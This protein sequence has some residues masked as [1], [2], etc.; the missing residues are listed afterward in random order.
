MIIGTRL[1]N[2]R[3]QSESESV[4][5]G[6]ARGAGPAEPQQLLNNAMR[7]ASHVYF[8]AIE[9]QVTHFLP[10]VN[11]PSLSARCSTAISY[12]TEMSIKTKS[13]RN[14][15]ITVVSFI[16][17]VQIA[18]NL[19]SQTCNWLGLSSVA[20]NKA[21]HKR[22]LLSFR[23]HYETA[24]SSLDYLGWYITLRERERISTAVVPRSPAIPVSFADTFAFPWQ[25]G[26]LSN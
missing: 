9:D 19:P 10:N 24:I 22:S 12:G 26:K 7:R 14:Q 15:E 25:M 20:N 13:W 1:S 21:S 2:P 16:S 17:S 6:K 18:S 11:R 5:Q 3:R 8:E 23:I 4:W